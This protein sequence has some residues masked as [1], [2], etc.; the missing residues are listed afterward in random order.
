ML[1]QL[2]VLE[3]KLCNV[4][5]LPMP[6]HVTEG[7]PPVSPALSFLSLCCGGPLKQPG[8]QPSNL[9]GEHKLLGIREIYV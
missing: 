6:S 3:Q 2:L 8:C 7:Y 1:R 5:V 9:R 4:T